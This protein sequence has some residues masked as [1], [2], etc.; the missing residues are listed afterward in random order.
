[1]H[2]TGSDWN[3]LGESAP[4]RENVIYGEKNVWGLYTRIP[5]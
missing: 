4:S 5:Y 3:G 2:Q 1:M